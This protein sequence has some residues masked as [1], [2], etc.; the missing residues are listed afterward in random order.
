MFINEREPQMIFP[1]G[2][3]TYYDNEWN[4]FIATRTPSQLPA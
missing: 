2:D 1:T 3:T 4:L